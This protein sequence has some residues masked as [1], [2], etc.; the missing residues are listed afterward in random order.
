M[1]NGT[2][3]SFVQDRLLGTGCWRGAQP[4]LMQRIYGGFRR[5]RGLAECTDN[6]PQRQGKKQI[7]LYAI[8]DDTALI[9]IDWEEAPSMIAR[10]RCIDRTVA[11]TACASPPIQKLTYPGCPSW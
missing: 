3:D 4:E 6:P 8:L 10:R 5:R 9:G 1:R 11:C 2:H 7:H